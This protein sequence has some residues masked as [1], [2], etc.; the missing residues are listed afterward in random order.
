YASGS[1]I[2]R[3]SAVNHGFTQP[4]AVGYMESHDEE[5]M[6]FK[7]ISYG[8]HVASYD[9]RPLDSALN[10]M[11]QAAC[12]FIPV[13]GPK[14]IYEFEELG[15]D[16]T[17]CYPGDQNNCHRTDPKPIKWNYLQY[18]PRFLL[19]KFFAALIDLK[20]QYTAFQ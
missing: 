8:N 3:I 16:Y 14:M 9:V 2:S 12:F 4:H 6:M 19:Y 10:R 5:R 7:E 18:N 13:P 17:I 15:Y 11:K 20:K 1:D